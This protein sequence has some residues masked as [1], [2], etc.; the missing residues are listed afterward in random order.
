[1]HHLS[2]IIRESPYLLRYIS[3]FPE[4]AGVSQSAIDTASPAIKYDRTTHT[5]SISSESKLTNVTLASVSG[6]QISPLAKPL[7]K[8]IVIDLSSYSGMIIVSATDSNG[9]TKTSKIVL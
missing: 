3:E 4:M 7:D 8:G 2:T 1:M 5:L 9:N 6:Q